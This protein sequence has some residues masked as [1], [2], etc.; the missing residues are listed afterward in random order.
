[1][2]FTDPTAAVPLELRT[3]EFVLRPITAA[4]AERDYAAVME[5]REQLRLWEQS[6]W[7]ADDFTVEDNRQDLVDLEERH[8]AHRAFTYAVV[9]PADTESWG[10]VYLFPTT[11]TF[12]ARSTVTPVSGDDWADVDAVAYFWVRASRSE[13][14][15]DA[16]LLAAV[17]AWLAGEW[18]FARTVYVTNEQFDQQVALL[19]STDLRLQFELVEPGKAGRYLVFG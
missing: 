11:A 1:M 15:L 18:G 13:T 6:T 2:T 5:T 4:D 9:D 17:R 14:G 8:R 16:R 10:C 12:L 3:G 7:P 19:A